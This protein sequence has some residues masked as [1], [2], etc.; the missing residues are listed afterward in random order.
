M[1]RARSLLGAMLLLAAP[2]AAQEPR[3]APAEV[4]P[5][6]RVRLTLL[7]PE[8]ERLVGSVAA[9]DSASVVVST[10]GAVRELRWDRVRRVEVSAGRDG[11]GRALAGA[12]IGALA[13][14]M[15]YR[16]YLDA[17]N[18]ADDWNGLV[19]LLRGAPAGALVGFLLGASVAPERW[20]PV[21]GT[22][23]RLL[24]APDGSAGVAVAVP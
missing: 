9:A 7:A 5:G 6:T 11:I 21:G 4:A 15:G 10:G 13:G 17:R 1:T 23:Y 14:G 8:G 22:A 16:W 12:G 24:V 2:L 20:R 19:A 18:E 3:T